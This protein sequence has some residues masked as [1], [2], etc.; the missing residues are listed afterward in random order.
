MDPRTAF[1]LTTTFALLNGAILGLL[2]RGLSTAIR[3]AAADWRIGTLLAAGGTILLAA[4]SPESVWLLIPVG[5]AFI[6]WGLALY[7]RS[8]RRFD[9]LADTNWIFAPTVIATLVLTYFTWVDSVLWIR[10]VIAALTWSIALASSAISLLRQRQLSHDIGRFTLAVILFLLT[11][12]ML[13]RAVYFAFWMRDANSILA[14]DHLINLLTPLSASILPVIGTTAFLVMC[15][16]RL[17]G[18][19]ALRA[20]ELDQKNIALVQAHRAREDAERIA[21]HDLKTP[22][23]SI[24]A[25]PALLRSDAI[26]DS[27]K[28]ALLGMIENAATRALNMV[29]LS[30]DLYRMENGNYQFEAQAVDLHEV[31]KTVMEDLRVHAESK[32]LQLRL[33]VRW[34]T[35][36]STPTDRQAFVARAQAALCYSCIANLLKNAI[37]AASDHSCVTLVLQREHIISLSLHNDAAVPIALRSCFFE[38][39][40]T[41]GKEGGTGLGTYSSHLLAKVQGGDLRMETSDLNGTTVTLT[42]APHATGLSLPPRQQNHAD[43]M[44][45]TVSRGIS[46]ANSSTPTALQILVVDDDS[47]N[48]KVIANQLLVFQCQI[49]SASNGRYGWQATLQYRFDLILMDLEMP[50]M[51]GIEALKAIRAT[52]AARGQAP[53]FIV[54]FSSDDAIASHARFIELGFDYCLSKPSSALTI[55]KLL[56][57]VPLA[58]NRQEKHW[59]TVEIHSHLLV[60]VAAFLSSRL[61]L[62]EELSS[63]NALQELS[64]IRSVAHKLSGSFAMYGFM[65][66]ADLCQQIELHPDDAQLAANAILDLI[67]YVREVPI[68]ELNTNMPNDNMINQGSN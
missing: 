65:W 41:Q 39:Y 11:A 13:I 17:R 3:P 5:N 22:L 67:Q 33:Q 23:A 6:F 25:T 64:K 51:N 45:S 14:S 37:E 57:Q 10:V 38:K 27:E 58:L 52:Q 7:W 32:H 66:A 34:P 28:E 56:Q 53:S 4:Q 50:V 46:S 18:E 15:S 44:D 68:I 35:D 42:L 61:Q 36:L 16:E 48:C 24:A 49:T 43:A 21:R 59:K 20:R 62:I 1:I 29:N 31:T 8:V 63:A 2:H 55:A 9:H 19:L 60:D 26:D 54:A 47:Y 12:F 40:A 30:L